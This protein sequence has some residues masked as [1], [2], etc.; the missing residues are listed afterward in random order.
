[1]ETF[2]KIKIAGFALAGLALSA[3]VKY[4]GGYDQF[5]QT[6][7][8]CMGVDMLTGWVAAAV[9]K[10]SKKTETGLLDSTAS[11]RGLMKKGCTLLIVAIAVMLDKLMETNGLTRDAVIIAFI[12]NELLSILENA[13]LMGIKM[14]AAF[15]G[16]IEWLSREHRR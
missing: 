2:H 5:L 3:A 14:P 8:G 15:T 10:R 4:L 16:A 12:L 6:L 11:F 1:V 13:G 7:V 9:F